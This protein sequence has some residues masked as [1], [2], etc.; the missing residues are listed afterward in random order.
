M[1]TISVRPKVLIKD[2]KHEE[3]NVGLKDFYHPTWKSLAL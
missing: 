2:T 1:V 3:I